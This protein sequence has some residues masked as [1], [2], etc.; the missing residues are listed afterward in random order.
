MAPDYIVLFDLILFQYV[1]ERLPTESSES[2]EVVFQIKN[3]ALKFWVLGPD[4]GWF[5][6]KCM[7]GFLGSV[8]PGQN[9]ADIANSF[10]GFFVH[11]YR[12][13]LVN[14]QYLSSIDA[15]NMGRFS[16]SSFKRWRTSSMAGIAKT[17]ALPRPCGAD[18]QDHFMKPRCQP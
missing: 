2:I 12:M 16:P 7:R 14:S 17:P 18:D 11:H 1:F 10:V 6:S 13:R 8:K 9:F 15:V 5:L 3:S 4:S